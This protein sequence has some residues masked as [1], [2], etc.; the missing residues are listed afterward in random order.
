MPAIRN[1]LV[2]TVN[3]HNDAFF[4]T[5]RIDTES[6]VIKQVRPQVADPMP[7]GPIALPVP[8]EDGGIEINGNGCLALLVW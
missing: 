7:A 1:A 5:I 2:V 4:G 3:R 6:G 8:A